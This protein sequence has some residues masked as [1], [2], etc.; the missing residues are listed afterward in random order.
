MMYG[1]TVEMCLLHLY[2]KYIKNLYSLML[3]NNCINISHERH[4]KITQTACKL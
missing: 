3:P 4:V 1:A 2:S